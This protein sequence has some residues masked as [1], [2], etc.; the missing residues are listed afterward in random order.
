MM[1]NFDSMPRYTQAAKALFDADSRRKLSLFIGLFAILPVVSATET[2]PNID[3]SNKSP[4]ES[5]A[6]GKKPNCNCFFS[7]MSGDLETARCRSDP[8]SKCVKVDDACRRNMRHRTIFSWERNQR[9]GERNTKIF[10]QE[11]TIC[12]APNRESPITLN[13][14]LPDCKTSFGGFLASIISEPALRYDDSAPFPPSL[15]E[16][17][18]KIMRHK[19]EIHSQFKTNSLID[20]SYA[21]SLNVVQTGK[22]VERHLNQPLCHD[23]NSGGNASGNV[24][25]W[26][27]RA[28]LK[29]AGKGERVLAVELVECS[30]KGNFI[31][32]SIGKLLNPIASVSVAQ[33]K[34]MATVVREELLAS[35]VYIGITGVPSDREMVE[36]SIDPERYWCVPKREICYQEIE[37]GTF[38][39]NLRKNRSAEISVQLVYNLRLGIVTALQRVVIDHCIAS[40]KIRIC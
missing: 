3:I 22:S 23:P 16:E 38:D 13:K 7:E 37:F 18:L 19:Y 11:L 21:H 40:Q 20:S 26:A 28:D 5:A 9:R 35:N 2:L 34:S 36:A 14:S 4:F 10:V 1:M 6:L 27:A 8:L 31:I 12:S 30:S 25:P 15:H 17:S 32:V 29:S 33:D 39:L 24:Y